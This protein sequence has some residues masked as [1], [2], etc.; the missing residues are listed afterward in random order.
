MGNKSNKEEGVI[1]QKILD[2]KMKDIDGL[3]LKIDAYQ[4]IMLEAMQIA[5]GAPNIMTIF[6][7]KYHIY[8]NN[9]IV[10]LNESMNNQKYLTKSN[11]A[12]I[13]NILFD[14]DS[15]KVNV[16]T[17][18]DFKLK[19]IYK[20]SLEKLE[21]REPYIDI[22]NL[23]FRYNSTDVSKYFIN[24]NELYNLSI[25]DKGTIMV[26]RKNNLYVKTKTT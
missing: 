20:I 17:P 7:N 22:N 15:Q 3:S 8:M 26:M 14:Y 11:N 23:V 16:V 9:L 2:E 10:D 5:T 4:L 6:E 24:N 21:N 18:T 13:I 19:N 25:P 12:S 1:V